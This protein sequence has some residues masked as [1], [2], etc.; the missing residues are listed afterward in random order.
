M[1]DKIH[2]QVKAAA[3][4]AD[5]RPDVI[6][7][8]VLQ[9]SQ[10]DPWAVRVEDGFYNRYIIALTR[11]TLPGWKPKQG[12]L[13]TVLTEKRVRSISWGLMQI[14]GET[15][16]EQGFK[17][18]YMSELLIPATNLQWGIKYFKHLYEQ[19]HDLKRALLRYNGGGNKFYPAEVLGRI[20]NGQ[21]A[22][23]LAGERIH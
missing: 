19:E 22:R 18:R 14:L 3:D 12:E 7:A 2:E 16:R 20:E 5:L 4:A 15:A 11:L 1:F 8:I 23:Y 21:V 13:P 9:E 17:G 6:A 10:G